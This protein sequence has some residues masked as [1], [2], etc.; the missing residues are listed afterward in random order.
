M[1]AAVVLF[2]FVLIALGWRVTGGRWLSV[3]SPSMGEAAPVGTLVLTRPTHLDQLRQ[4]DIISF[5]PT[6]GG[7]VHTH[8]VER[9]TLGQVFTK[10][11]INGAEDPRPVAEEQLVGKAVARWW[12]LA[13]LVKS[14]PILIPGSALVWLATRWTGSRWRTPLRLV[15]YPLVVCAAIVVLRPLVNASLL[16]TLGQEDSVRATV[17]ST[18]LLPIRV[19]TPDDVF[20]DLR[21]GQ[22]SDL[23]SHA[24]DAKGQV[25]LSVD[26]HMSW[27]WW[28]V[29][30]ALCSIPLAAS[31]YLGLRAN[32]GPVT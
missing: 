21:S 29:C 10:G 17:V 16:T 25:S 32:R 3:D 19:Q 1:L 13:W 15:G 24:A 12:G 9:I 27:L 4:G 6:G 20:A 31:V 22:V 28:T 18:G 2:T 8:R 14:L 11:D 26:A 7:P 23:V 5:T 30:F